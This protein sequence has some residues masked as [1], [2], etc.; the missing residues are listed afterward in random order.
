V[1]REAGVS[2][3]AKAGDERRTALAPRN[4]C[5]TLPKNLPQIVPTRGTLLGLAAA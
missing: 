3:K 4:G 1:F 5:D 2:S